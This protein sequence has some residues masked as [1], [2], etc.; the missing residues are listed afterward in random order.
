MADDALDARLG[1]ETRVVRPPLS[2][3]PPQSHMPVD[4]NAIAGNPA[5]R[6][7]GVVNGSG[8]AATTAAAGMGGAAC[9]KIPGQAIPSFSHEMDLSLLDQSWKNFGGS[10]VALGTIAVLKSSTS[11]GG[12]HGGGGGGGGSS[13]GGHGGS[14]G[15]HGGSGGDGRGNCRAG[16]NERQ[17]SPLVVVGLETDTISGRGSGIS[18][19]RK[20]SSGDDSETHTSGVGA[21]VFEAVRAAA[22]AVGLTAQG[23]TARAAGLVETK[24]DAEARK[25]R[26]CP[27]DFKAAP[28]GG[29]A[30]GGDRGGGGGGDDGGGHLGP[31]GQGDDTPNHSD[32]SG[33][34][35][36]WQGDVTGALST[37]ARLYSGGGDASTEAP[38]PTALLKGGDILGRSIS[39]GTPCAPWETPPS[40]TMYKS[41]SSPDSSTPPPEGEGNLE[42]GGGK[43]SGKGSSNSS[44]SNRPCSPSRYRA[45]VA[46]VQEAFERADTRVARE[47]ERHSNGEGAGVGGVGGGVVMNGSRIGNS[48]G[49][50]ITGC[51]DQARVAKVDGGSLNVGLSAAAAA[52][53]A[54]AAM[55]AKRGCFEEVGVSFTLTRSRC[56]GV[57]LLVCRCATRSLRRFLASSL[58]R[59]VNLF[60]LCCL[61]RSVLFSRS[62]GFVDFDLFV[63]SLRSLCL[64][65]GLS[66]FLFFAAS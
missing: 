33:R 39:P 65:V 40:H 50:A 35:R 53:A 32:G 31:L 37:T 26:D 20:S 9:R 44:R 7:G 57:A 41:Q 3:R 54:A 66:R 23:V 34:F 29:R 42:G 47:R 1:E 48:F 38:L 60:F 4:V 58:C 43:L 45:T 52:A 11:G 51:E 64:F 59:I 8:Q 15:G 5:S 27:S 6:G 49:G 61:R 25:I 10:D 17:V 28:G 21:P 55:T 2:Q 19:R 12:R 62:G 16:S 22:A 14:G 63:W 18:T 30:C 13:G 46:D 36:T 56:C 24:I